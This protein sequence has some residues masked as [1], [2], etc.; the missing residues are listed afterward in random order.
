M[1]TKV[2][3]EDGSI[4]TVHVSRIED[5]VEKGKVA[6]YNIED[7]WIEVRRRQVTDFGY[8]GPE[9]RKSHFTIFRRV[10]C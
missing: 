5:L 2:I 9:R 8:Q 4:K 6:A 1:K 7:K 10:H 3:Y